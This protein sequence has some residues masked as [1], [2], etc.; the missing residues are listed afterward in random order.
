MDRFTRILLLHRILSAARHPISRAKL[1]EQLECSAASVK[2]IIR[3]LRDYA[4]APVAYDREAN[5]YYYAK[6]GETPFELPGLWFSAQ[7]LLAFASMLELLA[8]LG[9]G[10]LDTT[11]R[12]FRRRLEQLLEAESLTL[13]ELPRR[14]RLLPLA[15][16][17]APPDVFRTTAAA[18]LQRR[19]LAATYHSR[20]DDN[21]RERELSPQRILHYRNNWYLDAW[22][23]LREELRTFALERLERVRLLDQPAI[24]LPEAWLDAHVTPAYGLFAGQPA[25]EAVL[26]FSAHRARWVAEESWHPAQQ[27]RWL[28]DG[29]Y[30]LRLPYG[31]PTELIM[32]ILRYGPEVEVV[33]PV[34]LR[35]QVRERLVAALKQYEGAGSGFEPAAC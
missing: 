31:N 16:R 20:S 9:P 18:T 1:E 3:E 28:D 17:A 7:E 32:D 23:H 2:R 6:S 21:R 15:G 34:K 8:G 29:R 27:G 12:P 5:G 11:L 25:A 24:E 4:G 22:C 19:R 26:H 13:A 14:L 35:E 33:A 10:L 30:E